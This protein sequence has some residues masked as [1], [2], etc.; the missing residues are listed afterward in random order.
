MVRQGG[1]WRGSRTA[2]THRRWLLYRHG[3]AQRPART[4]SQGSSWG[5]AQAA[6]CSFLELHPA[7]DPT[8]HI[9]LFQASYITTA[10]ADTFAKSQSSVICSDCS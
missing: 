10:L 3:L 5:N 4:S 2:A 6:S 9:P 1:D 7:N 8:K